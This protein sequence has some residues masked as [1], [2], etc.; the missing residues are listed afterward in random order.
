M[1]IEPIDQRQVDRLYHLVCTLPNSFFDHHSKID[2]KWLYDELNRGFGVIC[3][4]RG[5]DFGFLLWFDNSEAFEISFI[6]CRSES[7]RSGVASHMLNHL[8][9][10]SKSRK[11]WLEVN[12]K[13]QVAVTFYEKHGFHCQGKRPNYYPGGASALQYCWETHE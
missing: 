12:E 10:L 8:K 4:D 5:E 13:N 7:T 3:T 1:K 9:K 2:E 6:M 11:I